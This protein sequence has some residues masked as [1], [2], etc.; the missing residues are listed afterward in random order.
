M[1]LDRVAERF[2]EAEEVVDVQHAVVELTRLLDAVD[3]GID[4]VSEDDGCLVALNHQ[5]WA[6]VGP[7]R[8]LD[9]NPL[10]QWTVE[11]RRA[12]QVLRGEP[13][14]DP[15]QQERLSE[16]GYGALLLV[17][18]VTRGDAI[19]LLTLFREDARPWSLAEIRLAR[20]GAGQLAAAL[21]RLS[22]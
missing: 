12:V 19:G 9:E 18:V 11:S 4:L 13:M 8:P 6:N 20:I 2:G 3:V 7:V 10:L 5:S 21:E 17:P 15:Q 14:S 1:L 16:L 22:A